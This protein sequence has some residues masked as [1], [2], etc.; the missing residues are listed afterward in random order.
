MAEFALHDAEFLAAYASVLDPAYRYPTEAFTRAWQL[1]CL[2]QSHDIIPGSSIGPVYEESQQQ[3]AE[4]MRLAA[5]ARAAALAASAARLDGDLLLVNPTGFP[6]RDLAWLDTLADVP[7]TSEVPGT[8][9]ALVRADGQPIA[10]QPAAGGIWLAAGEL[11]PYSV[12]ALRLLRGEADGTRPSADERG[13]SNLSAPVRARPRPE[14]PL[15]IT[16][17][18]SKMPCSASNSTRPATSRASTIRPTA[19]TC[20]RRARSPTNSRRSRIA[21]KTGGLGSGHLLR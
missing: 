19:A 2:N 11:P 18:S 8:W 3:Y 21:P 15:S 20:C 12:K 17:P 9:P 7:G 13:V 14:N 4:V 5:D 16:L 10:I 6:R 1:V